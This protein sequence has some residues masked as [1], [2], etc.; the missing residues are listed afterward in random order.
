MRNLVIIFTGLALL[1]TACETGPG[2]VKEPPVLRVTSPARSLI[3]DH[4]GQVMVSGTAEPNASGDP[5]EEVLVNNV[6]ATL[7]EV[8]LSPPL[9]ETMTF[10]AV[11]LSS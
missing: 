9:T 11:S 6:R 4:A 10:F 3:Q 7:A 2:Q 8:I 1:A 5:V